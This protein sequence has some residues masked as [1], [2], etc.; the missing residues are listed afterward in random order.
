M[1]RNSQ[2][3]R[4]AKAKARASRR[5]EG[6]PGAFGGSPETYGSTWGVGAS[7]S[8]PARRTL[9]ERVDDAVLDAV[10]RLRSRSQYGVDRAISLVVHL[11]QEPAGA[12]A[13]TQR[14]NALLTD[15]VAMAWERGWQ[16]ADLDRLARRDL[17]EGCR[18]VLG[19]AMA[20]QLARFADTTIAP[21]WPAQLQEAG[22]SVWWGSTGDPVAARATTGGRDLD[23]VAPAAIRVVAFLANLPQLERL[24]PLPGT[25][26]PSARS[27][28]PTQV[29]ERML[30]RVR[31]LLAKAESTPYEAEAE[32]FTAGAQSLM[33]RHSIDAAMLA[34]SE[35][36]PGDA[37]SAR[38][39]GIDRPYEQPKV[40]LLDAVAKANR[41]RTVWSDALGFVTVIGFETDIAATETI[42]TSLLVQ[43]TAA[44]AGEGA[45][46]TRDGRSRTRAFRQ[47][48]LTAYASRIGARLQAATAEATEDAASATVSDPAD[49]G[50]RVS[51][52]HGQSTALVRV[53]A[54]RAE[55]VDARVAEI[56]PQV[57]FKAMS[58]PVDREGWS[59][60]SRA[61]DGA[62]L[63]SAGR[64]LGEGL[65]PPEGSQG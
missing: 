65:S 28:S 59:A 34:A 14:L 32:T 26:L 38:R 13:V 31:A 62:S 10:E 16:P 5:A 52:A 23:A 64:T 37:P 44:M 55:E 60:G 25:A 57:T 36:V 48:F 18:L 27:A 40:M 49:H 7:A 20:H 3:R 47:A 8:A 63:F 12:R 29:D 6:S 46:V 61:A 24:D 15:C 17:D 53:L 30:A 11:A 4:A 41:C 22:A 43:A 50:G 45:R 9:G 42:F 19:D 58:H 56:F 1:G 2:Q 35:R 51:R 33:A 54:D 39:V 21:R